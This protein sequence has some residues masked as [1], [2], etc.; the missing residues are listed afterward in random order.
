MNKLRGAVVLSALAAIA[1]GA[2]G[3]A[4]ASAQSRTVESVSA[5]KVTAELSY[6]KHRVN[7]FTTRYRDKRVRLLRDAQPIRDEAVPAKCDAFCVPALA[8]VKRKSISLRDLNGDGEPEVLVDFFTGGASCCAYTLAYGYQP[9]TGQYARATRNFGNYGYRLVDLDGNGTL[10]FQSGDARFYGAFS[11]G[12]CS[13]LP[14]QIW[15]FTGKAFANLSFRKYPTT[16]RKDAR[17]LYRGYLRNRKRG[18]DF[19]RGYLTPYVA[20][21]CLLGRCGTGLR[22]VERA[23][24]AGYLKKRRGLFVIGPYGR[25]YARALKRLLRRYGYLR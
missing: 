9:T 12:A 1:G 25:A 5:G 23:R 3:V 19:V 13:V 15:G 21:E 14:I 7:R 6:V 4:P 18:I 17:R 24:R 10:E 8:G 2:F 16:L 22:A 20:D 11:C